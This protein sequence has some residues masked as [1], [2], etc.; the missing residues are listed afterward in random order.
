[1]R[2]DGAG[3]ED[4]VFQEI[5]LGY[6]ANKMVIFYHGKSV[7]IIDIKQVLKFT[8]ADLPRDRLNELGHY[9]LGL[10]G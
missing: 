4:E 9:F 7:E 2:K 10:H 1:M 3:S 5:E 6:D 8:Q